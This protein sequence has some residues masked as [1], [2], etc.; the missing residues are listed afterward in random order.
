MDARGDLE[1]EERTL[2]AFKFPSE[3]RHVYYVL[4]KSG[5]MHMQYPLHDYT[6][7]H[8]SAVNT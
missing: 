1:P 4:Q 2:L 8:Y 7:K 5:G 6:R 3:Y